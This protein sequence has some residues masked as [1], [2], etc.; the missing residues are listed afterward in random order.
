MKIQVRRWRKFAGA[1]LLTTFDNDLCF[2]KEFKFQVLV[3]LG[4]NEFVTMRCEI[5]ETEE[6]NINEKV[7]IIKIQMRF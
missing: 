6:K 7:N 2:W 1:V 4:E 5:C 3:H